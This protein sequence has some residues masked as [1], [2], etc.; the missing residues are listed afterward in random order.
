MLADL[1]Q[2]PHSTTPLFLMATSAISCIGSVFLLYIWT[3][4]P[5]R[6]SLL[7]F[8]IGLFI[9]H[10]FCV[11]FII[12]GL[13]VGFTITD[14]NFFYFA[15]FPLSFLGWIF[16][17]AGIFIISPLKY[18]RGMTFYFLLWFIFS[19]ILSFYLFIVQ[20]GI[21]TGR[22][23]QIMPLLLFFIPIQLLGVYTICKWMRTKNSCKGV[24]CKIGMA[25]L[26]AVLLACFLQLTLAAQCVFNYPPHFW[27]FALY[28]CDTIFVIAFFKV[29][30]VLLGFLIFERIYQLKRTSDKS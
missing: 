21:F 4:E 23:F 28:S 2:V 3:K 18:T 24:I 14:L 11:P 15:S 17:Y 6:Y 12:A 20:G 13:K 10:L 7:V 29:L 9:G 5:K 27:F 8:A 30:F 16:I 22:F 19:I 26:I 1:L 25:M